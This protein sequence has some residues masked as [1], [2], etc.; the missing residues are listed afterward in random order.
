MDSK[1]CV[2]GYFKYLFSILFFW[3][4]SIGFGGW[5][6]RGVENIKR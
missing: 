1:E 5:G 3:I 4:R 2:I 6:R